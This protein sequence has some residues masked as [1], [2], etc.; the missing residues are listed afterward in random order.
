MLRE[1]G[2]SAHIVE[3]GK[4]IVKKDLDFYSKSFRFFQSRRLHF[5]NRSNSVDEDA[6]RITSPVWIPKKNPLTDDLKL[7]ASRYPVLPAPNRAANLG[8]QTAS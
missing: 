7:L 8:M 5:V 3:R 6:L 4:I 2:S 1:P